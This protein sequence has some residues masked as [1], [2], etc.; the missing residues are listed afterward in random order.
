[1]R[2]TRRGWLVAAIV[3]ASILMGHQFGARSL[4]ALVVPLLVVGLAAVVTV[5]RTDRPRIERRPIAAGFV[6]ET[7]IVGFTLDAESPTVATVVDRVG[8]GLRTDHNRFEVALGGEQRLEYEIEL[9]ARG[10]RGVGPTAVVVRDLLGLVERRFE[11]G[12][13]ESVMVYPPVY[14]LDGVGRDELESVAT[15]AREFERSA[16]DHL[17]E[18]RRGDSLRDVHWKSA[19][20]RPT[21]ELIVKEF[22]GDEGTGQLSIVAEAAPGRDDEMAAATATLSTHLLELGVDVVVTVPGEEPVT[23]G[24]GQREDVL[25]LTATADDG[26]VAPDLRETA[27]IRIRSG[28]DDVVVWIDGHE[29]SF[30]RIRVDGRTKHGSRSGSPLSLVRRRSGR[31]QATEVGP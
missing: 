10:R 2:P 19:A 7:R 6:G 12:S 20:K 8:P 5:A 28:L 16:F 21:D 22:A 17:R 23:A 1:M 9:V 15:A 29:R 14:E 24:P 4:N 18:Y 25:G 26:R 13:N 3:G 27:E 30:E 31:R 11:C